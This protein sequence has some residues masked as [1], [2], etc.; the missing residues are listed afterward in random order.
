MV[1]R[2]AGGPGYVE[3]RPARPS[4]LVAIELRRFLFA[5]HVG[6]EVGANHVGVVVAQIIENRAK[7]LAFAVTEE[8]R[9]EQGEG[10]LKSGATSDVVLRI[11]TARPQ[12]RDLVGIE[13]E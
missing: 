7:A 3:H 6:V 12:R 4:A 2:E 10:L 1:A 11:V 5:L 9:F 8:T 13:P